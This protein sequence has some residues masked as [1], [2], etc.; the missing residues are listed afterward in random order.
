M[1]FVVFDLGVADTTRET[2]AELAERTRTH[3]TRILFVVAVD[4]VKVCDIKIRQMEPRALNLLLPDAF[5]TDIVTALFYFTIHR[6]KLLGVYFRQFFL[7]GPHAFFLR[8][9]AEIAIV[10]SPFFTKG[11]EVK[12]VQTHRI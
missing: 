8:F 3:H 5:T 1:S 6:R 12:V 7:A 2:N 9:A 4:A 10:T 11:A